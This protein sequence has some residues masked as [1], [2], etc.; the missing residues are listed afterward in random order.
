[1]TNLI[2]TCIIAKFILDL[3]IDLLKKYDDDIVNHK[4]YTIYSMANNNV[5]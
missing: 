2:T 1:M 4:Y 5:L 3:F